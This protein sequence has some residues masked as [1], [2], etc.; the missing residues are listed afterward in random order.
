MWGYAGGWG[1]PLC[2]S[3]PASS[4]L[5][6][7]LCY[8]C[9]RKALL[10]GSPRPLFQDPHQPSEAWISEFENEVCVRPVLEKRPSERA[11]QEQE[12]LQRKSQA[13]VS[14]GSLSCLLLGGPCL[15]GESHSRAGRH[16]VERPG[17][18]QVLNLTRRQVNQSWRPECFGNSSFL[19]PFGGRCLVT[20]PFRVAPSRPSF[21]PRWTRDRRVL[22][23]MSNERKKWNTIRPLPTKKQVPLQFDVSRT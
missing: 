22:L 16:Q 23:V 13:P 15:V 12:V 10:G 2:S 21:L 11:R 1:S 3:H 18:G 6:G 19:A 20:W 5:V 14:H 8:F 7:W 4:H 17:G 9:R